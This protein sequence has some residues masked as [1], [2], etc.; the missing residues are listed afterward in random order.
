MALYAFDGTWDTD[1]SNDTTDS[2]SNVVRF[3]DAIGF[4]LSF[5]NIRHKLRLPPENVQ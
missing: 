1:K 5:L 3:H 2:N 4:D